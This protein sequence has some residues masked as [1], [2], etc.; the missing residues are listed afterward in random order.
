MVD[1]DPYNGDYTG[2]VVTNNT[3]AGGFSTDTPRADE[4]KG[5]DSHDAIIKSVPLSPSTSNY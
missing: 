3:I 2:T 5:A 1:Y 4:T